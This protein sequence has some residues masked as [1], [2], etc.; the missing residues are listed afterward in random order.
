MQITRRSQLYGLG[1]GRAAGIVRAIRA[2]GTAA[3]DVA[4]SQIQGVT[5]RSQ[6]G[7][8]VELTGRQALGQDPAPG[9]MSELFMRL[10]KPAVYVETSLGT[11]R[12]APWGEPTLNLYPVFVIGT[13]VGLGALAGVVARGL[14][15]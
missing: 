4:A 7:P 13:L 6:L 12:L 5:F 14:K 8:D 2:A 10:S 15:K 1:Q 9:G 3:G 11:M